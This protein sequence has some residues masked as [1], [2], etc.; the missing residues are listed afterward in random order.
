MYLMPE[1]GLII[2]LEPRERGQ[3][4]GLILKYHPL[5][6]LPTK[7]T[8]SDVSSVK[9]KKNFKNKSRRLLEDNLISALPLI[10]FCS[11]QFSI[12]FF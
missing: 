9:K 4:I 7:M 2:A 6:C 10:A 11:S 1:L 12:K 3:D 5:W 8:F